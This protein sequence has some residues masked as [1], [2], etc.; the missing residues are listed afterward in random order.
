MET[1]LSTKQ[2][3]YMQAISR[4]RIID[5]D[6]MIIVFDDQE[7]LELLLTL[8]LGEHTTVSSYYRQYVLKN[9]H[10]RDVEIDILIKTNY[11]QYINIEVQRWS[12]GAHPK[13]ARYHHSL[14]DADITLAQDKWKDIPEVIVIFITENDVLKGGLPIYHINRTIEETGE[15]FG[16]DSK[17]IYVNA[18][19]QDNT[20]LGRLMH[21]MM[22]KNYQDMYY[23]VLRNRVRYFKEQEGGIRTMCEIFDEIR[24]KG[25]LE[26]FIEGKQKGKLELI[27]HLMNSQNLSFQDV[28]NML[29][30]SIEEQHEYRKIIVS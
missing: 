22:C 6:F 10:G 19:Y 26:G 29:G 2:Q 23:E 30:I 12:E 3:D 8:I 11:N 9:L 4:L 24:Q 27:N 5:D 14:I 1:T 17:I 28:V 15:H 18:S 13:R 25:K 7:C 20:P 21:D 16:D